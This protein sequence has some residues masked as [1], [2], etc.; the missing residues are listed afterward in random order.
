MTSWA[1]FEVPAREP[2]LVRRVAPPAAA[3]WAALWVAAALAEALALRPVLLDR[4]APIQGIE[5]VFTLVGGSFAACGLV[6]WRRRPDS[7]SGMLM[8]ATGFAF[9]VSQLLSQVESE[10]AATLRV[11]FVDVWIFFFV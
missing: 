9:L 4:E 1:P 6:A 11:L 5:V 3:V 7:R 10:L 8:T 2:L